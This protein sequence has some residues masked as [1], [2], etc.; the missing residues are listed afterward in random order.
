MH[1]PLTVARYLAR[2]ILVYT[3][4]GYLAAFPII[5]I[6]NLVQRLDEFALPWI[7]AADV[8]GTFAWI[9][10]LVSAYALPISFLFGAMM[11][12]GRLTGDG[13]I[14][15]LRAGGLGLGVIAAVMLGVGAA[16]A[17]ASAGLVLGVEPRAQRALTQVSLDVATR[18]GMIETGRF[19]RFGSRMIYVRSRP[20]EERLGGVMISDWSHDERPFMI[21][22]EGGEI[23]FDR[24]DGV[25]HLVLENGEIRMEPGPGR[26]FEEYRLT[27]AR[28]DYTFEAARLSGGQWRYWPHQVDTA[29]LAGI[30]AR[31]EAGDPLDD[32]RFAAAHVYRIQLHRRWAVPL[33]ALLFALVA[34]AL[35]ARESV[36]SRAHG[37]LL[38][39][40]VLGGYYAFFSF[41][42]S[43][44][45]AG[46][47]SP[48]LAIWAPDAALGLFGLWLLRRAA[49]GMGG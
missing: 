11:A 40:L 23:R 21:F 46:R 10:P 3:G 32:L 14:A 7:T 9:V 13:E 45:Y 35:G 44:A 43:Q 6:P 28:F 26:D 30:I 5:L 49:T 24:N 4:I 39:G 2:E 48:A 16:T 38:A 1:A 18:G 20:S 42:Q 15:A 22:A 8:A 25:L 19:Q 29:D 47:V 37:L 12:L 31:A 33:A 36:R 41:A 34:V 27:F 17:T